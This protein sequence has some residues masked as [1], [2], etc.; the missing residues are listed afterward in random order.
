MATFSTNQSRQLYV[1]E[2]LKPSN[3]ISTDAVGSIAVKSDTA[4]N[5]LYFRY[6][7]SKNKIYSTEM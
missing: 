1:A 5:H 4:K 7:K 2:V 6:K 3:V